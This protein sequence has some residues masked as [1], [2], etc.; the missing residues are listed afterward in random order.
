MTD[1]KTRRRNAEKQDRFRSRA[2]AQGWVQINVWAPEA[3]RA[4]LQLQAE[5][6]RKYPHLM[7]GPLRDPM[8][9]RLVA[10]RGQ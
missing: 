8:T 3:A 7:V 9:G 4:D 5:V 2:I 1:E 6:L 10:L